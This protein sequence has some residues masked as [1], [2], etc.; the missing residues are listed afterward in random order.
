MQQDEIGE[1][2]SMPGERRYGYKTLLGNFRG[3]YY[4]GEIDENFQG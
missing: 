3:K 2:C 1:A 4:L